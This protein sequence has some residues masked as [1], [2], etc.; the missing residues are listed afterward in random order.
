MPMPQL[1]VRASSRRLDRAAGLE[2]GEQ[3]GQGP[4]VGV[5]HGVSTFRQDARD[6]FQQAAAG[7]VGQRLDPSLADQ[8]KQALHIDARRLEQ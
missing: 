7:D 3:A 5:D 1:K 4:A 6:I 2:E 8:R